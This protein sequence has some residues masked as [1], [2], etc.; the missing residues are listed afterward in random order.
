MTPADIVTALARHGTRI[1]VEGERVRLIFN[2]RAPPDD[3]VQAAR[4]VKAVL[5]EI[6]RPITSDTVR[7][8]TPEQRTAV[9]E[10]DGGAPPEWA[11]A[12]A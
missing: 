12:F 6:V 7:G 5:R 1:A 4:E 10:Y 3:L 8:E 11:E 2:G 9:V